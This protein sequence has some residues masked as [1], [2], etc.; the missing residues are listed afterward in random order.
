M[1]AGAASPRLHWALL[2]AGLVV[3][4]WS[5]WMPRDRFTWYL[6]VAPG[7]IAAAIIAALYPRWRF[8]PL[9]LILITIHAMI[10]MVGGKY[11]YAEVRS[12]TGCATTSG[13]RAITTTGSATL[14]KD[15]CRRWSRARSSFATAFS[16]AAAGSS[17]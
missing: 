8:T 14:R 6:E 15:S 7:P 5:G 12:S 9:V 16:R 4:A 1:G 2:A 11:T 3:L 17:S 13:S 10:L